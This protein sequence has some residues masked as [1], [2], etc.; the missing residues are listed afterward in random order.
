[1]V[2]ENLIH[3]CSKISDQKLSEHKF[4]N[5]DFEMKM[6]EQLDQVLMFSTESKS[7]QLGITFE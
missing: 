3:S 1:M 2:Q 5:Q 7:I 4:S 6:E